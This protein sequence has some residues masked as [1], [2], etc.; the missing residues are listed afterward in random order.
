MPLYEYKCEN[1]GFNFEV[2]QKLSDEPL[3]RCTDENCEGELK[4]VFFASPIQFKC[5]GFTQGYQ[6]K[7]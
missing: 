7:K 6:N 2:Q 5:G 1:C 3:K 4:K